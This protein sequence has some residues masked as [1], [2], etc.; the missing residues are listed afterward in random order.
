MWNFFKL[1]KKY[2]IF[3]R[4]SIKPT[5][6]LVLGFAITI[7]IG[8]L[9]LMLPF[10]SE[11][12]ESTEFLTAL[13]TATSAVCVTGL[14]VVDTATYW[15]PIGQTIIL[16]LIQIG[17]IG[18]MSFATLI[19]MAS[20][21]KITFKERLILQ[22]GFNTNSMAGIVRY[23]RKVIFYTFI[24]EFIGAIILSI[25]FMPNFGLRKGILMGIFHSI[26]AFCNA[27][28]DII[29][30]FRSLTPFVDNA[31]ISLT[32]GALFIIGGLGFFVVDDIIRNR[33]LKK[34]SMHSK[35]VISIT[36][37]LIIMGTILI[38][39]FEFN[40]PQTLKGLPWNGKLIASLFQAITPR[41][42]GFN[43]LDT[44]AL[45]MTS[46]FLVIIFMFIGG[47]PGSTAGGVKTTTIGA[48]ILTVSSLLTGREQTEAYGKT[49]SMNIIKRSL[50]V[51]AIAIFIIVSA[52]MILTITEKASFLE[53][54]FEVFS[55]FGTVGLSMGLTPDLT[56]VGRL[57]MIFTMFIGRLGPL[58]IAFA[59]SEIQSAH[60]KSNYKYPNGNILVG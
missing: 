37:F 51:I 33:N 30:G 43:T 56:P 32:V 9:L 48:I 13:F 8:S 22:E 17:G 47:S 49:I 24:V 46:L 28:F 60:E 12:G 14:V 58:T 52:I 40:N 26:S 38:F 25:G 59:I 3:Q 57:V 50:A 41:T 55:G 1:I 29:G 34:I 18:F 42:A 54:V 2:T 11:S 39:I 15:S 31:I 4:D 23:T 53:I 36:A 45:T 20:R 19:F 16:L 21:K 44:G 6:I 5:Q 10:S 35:L 27:G 7:L